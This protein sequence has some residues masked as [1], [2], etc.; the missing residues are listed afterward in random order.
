MLCVIW[1]NHNTNSYYYRIVKGSYVKYYVGYFNQYN[2]EVVL[3]IP[4]IYTVYRKKQPFL[5]K[6]LKRLISFLQNINEK[7]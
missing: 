5:K 6:V 1:H 7:F 3:L 4:L 2:H